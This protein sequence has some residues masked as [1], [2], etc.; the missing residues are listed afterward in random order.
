LIDERP[1]HLTAFFR[2]KINRYSAA[3]GIDRCEHV[4]ELPPRVGR[5][6]DLA[7]ESHAIGIPRPFNMNDI[8]PKTTKDLSRKCAHPPTREIKDAQSGQRSRNVSREGR[9]ER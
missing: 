3:I 7:G 9:G 8:S 4:T 2:D 6:E 5:C 1:Q